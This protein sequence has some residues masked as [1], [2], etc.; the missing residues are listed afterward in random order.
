MLDGLER[1]GIR[2]EAEQAGY[3]KDDYLWLVKR[4]GE[5]LPYD[6]KVLASVTPFPYNIQLGQD[7]LAEICNRRLAALAQ[8]RGALEH[9]VHRPRRGRRRG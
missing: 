3:T 8:C 2:A 5:R 9:P 7:R 6:L 1:L 4:T